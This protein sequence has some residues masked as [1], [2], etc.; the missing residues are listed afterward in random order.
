MGD[1]L[2]SVMSFQPSLLTAVS[3]ADHLGQCWVMYPA[4]M[5]RNKN[6]HQAEGACADACA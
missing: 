1:S 6:L 5:S 2:S 4:T 3:T